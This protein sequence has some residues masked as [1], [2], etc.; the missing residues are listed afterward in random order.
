MSIR[1]STVR[2][3]TSIL[4]KSLSRGK[5]EVSISCYA[6]LFSELVQY[7]QNRVYTVPELQNKLAEIG[8][9]VG[10][11]LIDLLFVRERN[12]KREIKLLNMLLFIKSTLWK[13]LF[14]KEADKLEHANDDERTYYII[15]K[16][17]L[18][19]K[20]ISVPKDKSSLNCATFI[21]GIVE[22][23]LNGCGFPAKVTAHWHK[24]TT[25]M[26]K[27]DDSVITKDKQMEER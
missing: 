15:E 17:P 25:Y 1:I 4:D 11:R 5:G 7:C 18:V 14:G 23:F 12:C 3:K 13:T 16:E 2:P 27:F 26:V 24:G 10:V 21:A 19:N 22:A 8:Q 20:F 9:D 6:L